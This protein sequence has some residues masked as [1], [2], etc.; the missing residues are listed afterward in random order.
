MRMGKLLQFRE[1]DT[2]QLQKGPKQ[3]GNKKSKKKTKFLYRLTDFKNSFYRT[4]HLISNTK[5][6]FNIYEAGLMLS[7]N[8]SESYTALSVLAKEVES[9]T[10]VRGKE[11]IDTFYLSPMY[12]LSKLGVSIHIARH[13]S[14]HP[15]EYRISETRIIIKAKEHR[16]ELITSGYRFEKLERSFKR[17][18]YGSKLK[19]VRRPS[20]KLIDYE[21]EISEAP[22]LK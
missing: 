2:T 16:L 14:F 9:I 21:V 20:H 4:D 7:G 1:N 15:S 17:M 11:T 18:G 12:I 3:L 19:T 5:C 6:N 22:F 13:L 10:M 8:F